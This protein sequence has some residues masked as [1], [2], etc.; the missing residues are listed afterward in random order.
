VSTP[1]PDPDGYDLAVTER[2]ATEDLAVPDPASLAEPA[3][4]SYPAIVNAFFTQRR[5]NP[6]G[7]DSISGLTSN[8]R[9][10][11]LHSGR[12][13][14]CTWHD[15]RA[16]VVWLLAAHMHRSG[17]ADDAYPYF[18]TLDAAGRLVPTE[19]D[20][21]R[22]IDARTVTFASALLA[23]VPRLRDQ[24]ISQPGE[25][26]TGD[27]GGRVDVRLLF[28]PDDE[29][30]ILTVAISQRL[31]PGNVELPQGWT[32]LLAGAFLSDTSI[33]DLAHEYELG[34][35]P[36]EPQEIAFSDFYTRRPE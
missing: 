20:Y 32:V 30:P 28:E 36:L 31:R 24:A 12:L 35:E 14:G 3:D 29:T 34:G 19:A 7:Q 26:L 11:S 17:E 22:V 2:C 4:E 6:I 15:R 16:A 5:Q 23:D 33:E 8:L 1:A 10:Y 25:I 18:L 13:R 27:I 9:A 21:A